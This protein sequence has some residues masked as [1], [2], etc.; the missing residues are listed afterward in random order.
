MRH[1][2]FI[3]L[4]KKFHIF[5]TIGGLVGEISQKQIMRLILAILLLIG[6]CALADKSFENE[7][8]ERSSEFI[9]YYRKHNKSP[10]DVAKYIPEKAWPIIDY[11]KKYFIEKT[12]QTDQAPKVRVQ[13]QW[14]T[15]VG[16]WRGLTLM[17]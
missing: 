1:G 14:V 10:P 4:I 11:A 9:Q 5:F 7:V 17:N 13:T 6:T 2:I 15:T 12:I 8:F 16:P 3:N